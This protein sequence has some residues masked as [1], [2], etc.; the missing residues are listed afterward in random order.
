[1]KTTEEYLNDY[2]DKQKE[3]SKKGELWRLR[4]T[5]EEFIK[6]IEKIRAYGFELRKSSSLTLTEYHI[7]RNEEGQVAIMLMDT[8]T[9]DEMKEQVRRNKEQLRKRT[10]KD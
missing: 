3:L 2:L 9:L 6:E 10:D 8:F 4:V 7:Q 1:M 5:Q